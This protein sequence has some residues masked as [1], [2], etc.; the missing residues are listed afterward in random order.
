MHTCDPIGINNKIIH[1]A[2]GVHIN[3]LEK[4]NSEMY[5]DLNFFREA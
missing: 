1:I 4:P 2:E 3:F 5:V